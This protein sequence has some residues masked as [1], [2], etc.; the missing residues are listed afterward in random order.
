M[1]ICVAFF[2]KPMYSSAQF[3]HCVSASKTFSVVP[4]WEFFVPHAW[5]GP[6]V[7]F[8]KEHQARQHLWQTASK[9]GNS[10]LASSL[11]RMPKIFC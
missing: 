3:A 8:R 4:I 7:G 10:Q 1:S 9:L 2:I 6:D 5:S 11:G